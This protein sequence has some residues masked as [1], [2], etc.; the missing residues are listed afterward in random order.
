MRIGCRFSP[1]NNVFIAGL[2]AALFLFAQLESIPI[3]SVTFEGNRS[4]S[5]SQLKSRLLRSQQGNWYSPDSLNIDL[6]VLQKLYQDNGYLRAELG[7]PIVDFQ[8]IGGKKGAVIRIPVSEGSL[9]TVGEV[10]VENV[11]AFRPES[12]LQMC[13]LRK[14]EPYS[15]LKAAQWQAKIEE[16]YRSIGYIRFKSSIHE[17]I[18]ESSRVVDCILECV[19]GKEYR[20][21]KI[22][23]AGGEESISSLDFRR[24]LLF[25]E[26]G[27]F[28][29]EMVSLSIH[30]INQMS[31]Y[32]PITNSDV[33]VTIDDAKGLVNFVFH[34]VPLKKP[35]TKRE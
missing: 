31:L 12:L 33:K 30:Y 34:L 3:V 28:S 35:V 17:D 26:G 24:Q 5:T 10:S 20:I 29:P 6:Q 1:I 16:G 13:P 18:H 27:V 21:G 7:P 14:E 9:Y 2:T 8:T 19:E 4:I 11:Q 22:T 23:L 32:Q 15:R 25:S